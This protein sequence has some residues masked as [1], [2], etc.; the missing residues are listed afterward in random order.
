MWQFADGCATFGEPEF[1]NDQHSILQALSQNYASYA[2]LNKQ[3]AQSQGMKYLPDCQG[4]EHVVPPDNDSNPIITEEEYQ[5]M[6]ASA[7]AAPPPTT[8]NKGDASTSK[9][10]GGGGGGAAVGPEVLPWAEMDAGNSDTE[11]GQEYETQ[12]GMESMGLFQS[13]AD[14]RIEEIKEVRHAL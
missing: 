7:S 10:S 8:G 5:E 2:L 12:Q 1:L 13:Q 11:G 6:V 4:E 3:L 9:S 14:V